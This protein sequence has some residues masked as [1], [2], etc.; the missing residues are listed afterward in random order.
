MKRVPPGASIA[1]RLLLHSDRAGDCWLW[2]ASLNNRGYGLVTT[3]GRRL[4]LAHRAAYE[5]FVGPIPEGKHLDHLCR[6]RRCINPTHLEPVTPLENTRRSP[7]AHGSESECPRGH[8]YDEANTYRGSGRRYCRRCTSAYRALYKTLT[9]EDR[10]ARISA[11][12]P[13]VD[14]DAHFAQERAA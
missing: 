2:T 3:P 14:L 8:R 11:G 1:E 9:E 6:V 10:A 12:L 7:I 5:E 13:L 4:R